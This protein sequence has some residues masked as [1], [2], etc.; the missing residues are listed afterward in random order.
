[1]YGLLICIPVAACVKILMVEE[2]LPR[3]RQWA[4]TG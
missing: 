1:M 4:R 3:M 2:V